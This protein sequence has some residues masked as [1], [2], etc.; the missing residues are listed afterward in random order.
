VAA[1]ANAQPGFEISIPKSLQPAADDSAFASKE[2]AEEFLARYLPRATAGNP[3]YRSGN[4]AT[5]TA[6]I[7]KTI[8]FKAGRNA[9]DRLVSM[10][11]EVLEIHNGVRSGT[12]SHE[13][14]FS[15]EDVK[16]T[17]HSDSTTRTE[18]GEIAL[19]IVFNCDSGK[20]IKSTHNGSPSSTEWADIYI[21]SAALRGKIL[22]AFEALKQAGGARNSPNG[23]N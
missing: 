21:Q 8:K 1:P 6:W 15:I 9:N 3:K 5:E 2:S 16:V 13:V 23:S 10:S 11:E 14:E 22:K 20:C 4:S 19:G 7:T 18:S 12:G 17:E